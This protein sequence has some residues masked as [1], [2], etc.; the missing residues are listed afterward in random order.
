MKRAGRKKIG[1]EEKKEEKG[2]LRGERRREKQGGRHHLGLGR[3]SFSKTLLHHLP[4]YIYCFVVCQGIALIIVGNMLCFSF[5]Y[6]F[7]PILHK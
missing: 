7:F 6:W 4:V 2:S 3:H 1:E 5:H